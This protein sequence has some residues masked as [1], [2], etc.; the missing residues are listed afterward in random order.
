MGTAGD[1][2]KV[3]EAKTQVP[4]DFYMGPDLGRFSASWYKPRIGREGKLKSQTAE[5]DDPKVFE[6]N[7]QVFVIFTW[8]LNFVAT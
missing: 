3:F 8:V 6:A 2:P 1:D 5:G 4:R 7:I